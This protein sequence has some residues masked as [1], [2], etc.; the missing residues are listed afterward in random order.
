MTRPTVL[1]VD[2][3]QWLPEA[4][5]QLYRYIRAGAEY[6]PDAPF[7]SRGGRFDN[8]VRPTLYLAH[9]PEGALAEFFKRNP[10]LLKYQDGLRLEMYE[11][12]VRIGARC[13]DVRSEEA[14]HLANV[15][16][17]RLMSNAPDE[18]ERYSYSREVADALEE[19]SGL[20]YPSAA[21]VA[22][23]WNIVLF[24][25][26]GNGWWPEGYKQIPLPHVDPLGVVNVAL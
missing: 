26:A 20:A 18:A 6:E 11:V 10:E 13:L 1:N 8:G 4:S 23:A 21:L 12:S 24:G 22:P 9:T 25:L 7:A 14:A 15:D 17:P 2:T 16:L 5:Y 19:E 3:A